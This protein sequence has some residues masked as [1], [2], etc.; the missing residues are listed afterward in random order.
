MPDNDTDERYSAWITTDL[1]CLEGD[2]ADVSVLTDE[3]TGYRYDSD[4]N[5]IPVWAPTS[6]DPLLHFVTTV[7]VG[8]DTDPWSNGLAEEANDLLHQNGWRVLTD[9]ETDATGAVADVERI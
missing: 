4:G 7:A 9:W 5:E 1:T 8:P 2:L 6:A 3:I